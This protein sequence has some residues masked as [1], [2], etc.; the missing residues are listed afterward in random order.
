[1]PA[2]ARSHF[3]QDIARAGGLVRLAATLP[4]GTPAEQLLAR[5]VLRS[6]WMFAVGALDAYFCDAHADLVAAALI[7]KSRVPALTLPAFFNDIRLP[8]RAILESYPTN[9]N[10]RWRMAA[11]RLMDRESVL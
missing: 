8:V 6:A 5:D 3:D 7:A 1:M 4:T 11:R 2:T 10:L 9:P